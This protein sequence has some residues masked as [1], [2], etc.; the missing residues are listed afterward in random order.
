MSWQLEDACRLNSKGGDAESGE[1][2]DGMNDLLAFIQID[3][4]KWEEYAE[5]VNALRGNDPET[6]IEFES[7]FPDQALEARKHG[8]RRSD[9]QAEEALAGLIVD[10]IGLFLHG[11]LTGHPYRV[12]I[13]VSANLSAFP[14]K[15]FRPGFREIESPVPE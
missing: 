5:S 12:R 14:F 11:G 7:E 10:A 4:V 6:F 3:E 2:F 1:V 15:I 13:L 8:V 9:A